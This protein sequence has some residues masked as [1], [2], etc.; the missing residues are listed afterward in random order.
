MKYLLST[1][2]LATLLLPIG[3]T[4]YAQTGLFNPNANGSGSSF[5]GVSFS[6]VGAAVLGCTNI[7]NTVAGGIRS[8]AGSFGISSGGT[9]GSTNPESISIAALGVEMNPAS[10][11]Q[12]PVVASNTDK[13]LEAQKKKE[14]C[15][16]AAA[17]AVAKS[18][19]N[20]V[21]SMTV[22]WV[23]TG[24]GGNPLYVRD[25]NSYLKS[26]TDERVSLFLDQIPNQ[27]PIFGNT[28]R[29]IIT[30][31]VSGISDGLANEVMDTPEA[32]AYESFQDDF[33]NGGWD[34]F[35]DPR[36]NAV[37]AVF[38]AG[39]QISQDTA[40]EEQN[41]REELQT[42]NGFLD[43]KQCVEYTPGKY[44]A[45]TYE[46][47]GYY[48][49]VDLNAE[50]TRLFNQCLLWSTSAECESQLAYDMPVKIQANCIN[51]AQ[52]ASAQSADRQCIRYSTT[53]P[54]KVISDQ[55]STVLSSHIRQL[56][57]ADEI[58]EVIGGFF[59]ALLE[60]LFNAG[61]GALG[62]VGNSNTT[63]GDN[64]PGSNVVFGT[65]G[66][67]VN[68]QSGYSA[69]GISA[70]GNGSGYGGDFDVS[71]PQDI[72]LVLQTQYNY[73]N[74]MRDSRVALNRIVPT[75]GALDYCIPGPNP[76][77]QNGLQSNADSLLG[78]FHGVYD[79]GQS[80]AETVLQS[81]PIIGGLFGG[82]GPS[83]DHYV[84]ENVPL[85]DRITQGQFNSSLLPVIYKKIAL[86]NGN[87]NLFSGG[88]DVL[89]AFQSDLTTV[90]ADYQN[91][92]TAQNLLSA[93]MSVDP[94][95]AQFVQ[96][97]LTTSTNETKKLSQ[98]TTT[99]YEIDSAYQ[100]LEQETLDSIAQLEAI[101]AETNEIV[102]TAKA[103]YIAEQAAAGTPINMAC[104][105]QAYSIDTSPIVPVARQESDAP[106]PF[107]DR[108][109]EA[110]NYFYN[111]I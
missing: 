1:F 50:R 81:I 24:M 91:A 4:L 62:G 80:V 61:L 64:G 65:N 55:V 53:T 106:S 46:Y 22:K 33:R 95:N 82:G 39:D 78:G 66:S 109:I 47:Q 44:D 75:L 30:Q 11:N 14:T 6:G 43:V 51:G 92:F 84:I 86:I 12:V 105:N 16:D 89:G 54:G 3:S 27:D 13:K 20:Q 110:N 29:S 97:F 98:Y 21:V 100:T 60:R 40:K 45:Y 23:N 72:R 93:F 71:R 28:I 25:L 59:D 67:I 26:V 87:I 9:A 37:S 2:L 94:N 111:N 74:R 102:A 52:A 57:N 96:G 31:S 10:M 85:F 76:D 32:R 103:R 48:C 69:L 5:G 42:N 58:N 36:N 79:N 104:I 90:L 68:V 8:L 56:E 7:G 19:L 38:R 34:A 18:L 83:I 101:R 17:Y 63:F 88:K 49:R 41:V 99:A 73:L 70:I 107:F 77:W 108:F 15:L 35:L